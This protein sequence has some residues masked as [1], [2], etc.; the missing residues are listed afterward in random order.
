MT[1]LRPAKA[2]EALRRL[3]KEADSPQVMAGGQ[4][5]T[6]W[7][8]KVRS[9]VAGA[10][11]KD[12]S[13]VTDLENVSYTLWAFGVD[14]TQYEWDRARHSG[15]REAVGLIDAA[16][17]QMELQN[18]GV[19]LLDESSFDAELWAHVANLVADQDWPKVAAQAAIFVEDRLKRWAGR[20]KAKNGDAL[21]GRALY[22]NVLGIG[23]DFE[24]GGRGGESEGWLMLGMGFAQVLGNVDRHNIQNRPDARCYAIGVLGVA[25][26]ILTQMRYEHPDRIDDS[27]KGQGSA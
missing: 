9:V 5:F 8:K 27:Y 18:D 7:Q 3:A 24:L 20:P 12:D 22:A 2:I 26:L 14:T 15:I 13:L 25:S 4:E 6:A 21:Y 16:I 23:S 11:G 17:Y 1:G 10:L 19:D